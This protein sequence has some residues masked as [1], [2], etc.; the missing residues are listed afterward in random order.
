MFG[1]RK[2]VSIL[3][4]VIMLSGLLTSEFHRINTEL[5]PPPSESPSDLLMSKICELSSSEMN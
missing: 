2:S 4:V 3:V 5:F 1:T